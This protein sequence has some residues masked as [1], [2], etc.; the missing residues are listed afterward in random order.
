MLEVGHQLLEFLPEKPCTHAAIGQHNWQLQLCTRPSAVKRAANR[1]PTHGDT[2]WH[3]QAPY[4]V[5]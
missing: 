4:H 1:E 5:S 2:F 3:L